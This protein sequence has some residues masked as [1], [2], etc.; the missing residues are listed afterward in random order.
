MADISLRMYLLLCTGVAL[1]LVYG[2][3]VKSISLVL[4]NGITLLLAGIV[5]VL[6][7]R[8]RRTSQGQPDQA[9]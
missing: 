1:W 3:F 9:N 8:Y 7:L 6:K 5:L 2:L 4:T